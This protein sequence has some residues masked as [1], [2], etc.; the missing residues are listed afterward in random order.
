MQK[1]W[2]NHD[3]VA[4]FHPIVEIALNNALINTGYNNIAEVVHHPTIPNSTIV[5]DFAIRLKN[6]QRYVF[7]IE[8]KRTNRDVSS[9]RYQN[10]SRNY[11]TEFAPHWQNNYHK[12]FCVTNVEQLILFADRQ[13][14]L[15]TCVLKSNLKIHSPFER[16]TQDATT[17][18][19]AFQ[20]T[21]EDIFRVIFTQQ[22]PDWDNN[23]LPIIENF[24][25]NYVSLKEVLPYERQISEELSLYELFRLFAFV[26]LREFYVQ[27]GNPNGRHFRGLP[28]E[29][30]DFKRFSSRL[31]NS[32]NRILQLDFRQVF[33]NHPNATDRIFPENFSEYIA[34][35]FKGLIHSL[36]NHGSNAVR[37]N[38]SPSYIFDLLT[39]KVY[40]WEQMHQKGKIMSDAELANLL[41]TLTIQK[42]TDKILDS[43]CGDGSLLNAAYDQLEYLGSSDSVVKTHNRL[44]EQI[45]GIEIDPFLAQL[46]TFRL[47]SKN[48]IEVDN[49]TE[50]NIIIGDIF[51]NPRPAEFDVVM[52]NP[53]FLRN[54]NSIAPITNESKELMI[55]AIK[56][57]GVSSIFKDTKQPNLY[58]YFVNYIWHYLNENGRA[59]IILMT[60][61]LNNK[62]GEYLKAFLLDKVEA[63]I[64]YPR[65]YFKGFSVTT[66]I[67]IL[68]KQPNEY[69]KFLN[70]LEPNLLE[71]PID[72]KE[73]LENDTTTI[74][75]D[76]TLRVTDRTINPKD[77][78]KLYLT[79]PEDKF[80]RLQTL[81]FLEP[82]TTFFG[83]V[84]RGG[85]E[86]NGGSKIIYSKFDSS[87]YDELEE[88]FI[89]Y[90]IKNS[91]YPRSYIL[92]EDDLNIDKAIHFPNKYDKGESYGL[93]HTFF[94][95]KGLFKIYV[96]QYVYNKKRW[97][98]ILNAAYGNQIKF[99]ILIPRAERAKHSSYYNP[100]DEKVVL[101]TNFFYLS[102]FQN[103]NADNSI[104]EEVQKKFITAYLL[105]SFGQIQ[106]EINSNNQEG[107]RKMEGFHIAQFK[108][109]DVRLF[110]EEEIKSVVN[111]FDALNA[112]NKLF[113]GDEGINT[114]RKDLDMVIG[115]IIYN[116]NHLDFDNMVRLVQF[117]QLF[118]AE[119]VDERNPNE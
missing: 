90:G 61:F 87:P 96:E 21:M 70:I 40:D 48:L 116:R 13:G 73:I 59:G 93:H 26:Y 66:V 75:V 9:Q 12:Y 56:N 76:F 16:G 62:E 117:F 81:E 51:T 37:D 32:Y 35:Y 43:G 95:K 45:A 101:S 47:I 52:M 15:S 114:P 113:R 79:D 14:P 19:S 65:T 39:S 80:V 11:V 22:N 67:V 106:Y 107:L 119:L 29:R 108:V 28:S 20:S 42:N 88:E 64:S 25:Q 94:H 58:F 46:T 2:Y 99:D 111:A 105:S 71:E 54:D 31:E 98:K 91:R 69:I 86:N 55:N 89:G 38:A 5:P 8:V 104:S 97:V 10:Q 3:E 6:S 30:D 68:S 27:H 82:L 110:S 53:P 24:Y 7:I 41:A 118:L 103:E 23:W 115:Q 57:Q 18:I 50:A 49:N 85:A 60:K 36:N 100:S 74:G 92:T 44:L 17:T 63:V 72:I 84:K 102:N 109:P 83:I 77:N 4:Q 33:S 112:S 34:G 78:W 1:L